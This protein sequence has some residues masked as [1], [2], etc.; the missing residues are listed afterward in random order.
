MT[1]RKARMAPCSHEGV[2]PSSTA[3]CRQVRRS[4]GMGIFT[5]QASRQ[6]PQRVEA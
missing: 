3:R 6:A 4:L 2:R 5:G 1:L